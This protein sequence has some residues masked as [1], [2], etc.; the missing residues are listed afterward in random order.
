VVLLSMVAFGSGF[1]AAQSASMTAMLVRVPASGFA[2]VSAVWNMAYDLGWGV[3][4]AGI[5]LVVAGVGPAAGFAVS[6]VLV[7]LLAGLARR[8][9]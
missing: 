8:A 1:G 3:G 6:G 9:R 2:T 4:A 7:L 5:G